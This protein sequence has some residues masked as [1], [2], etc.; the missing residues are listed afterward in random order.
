M[1]KSAMKRAGMLI[2]TVNDRVTGTVKGVPFQKE[3][4]ESSTGHYLVPLE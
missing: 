1:S 2:D 3:L 4:I